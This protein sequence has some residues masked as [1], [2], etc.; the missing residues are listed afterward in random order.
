MRLAIALLLATPAHAW[1]FTATPVC[2]LTHATE[3]AQITLTYDPALP[4]YSIALTLTGASWPDAPTFAMQFL[5][6]RALSIGT[7]QH[8]VS[9]D[10]TTLTVKDRGFGNVLDGLQYNATAL[11]L[12]GDRAL[13]IPLDD[14]ADPVAAFRRCPEPGLS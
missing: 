9:D 13:A 7:G 8:I 10:E 1:E 6:P 3:E 11:A 14:A 4:E 2:T 12:S 5:G